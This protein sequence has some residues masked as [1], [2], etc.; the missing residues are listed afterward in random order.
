[1]GNRGTKGFRE[2][3]LPKFMNWFNC[4]RKRETPAFRPESN[5]DV[6][7]PEILGCLFIYP[8]IFYQFETDFSVA[9]TI[10]PIQVIS[11]ILLFNFHTLYEFRFSDWLICTT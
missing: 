11:N 1:M 3:K 9:E 6:L 8:R 2:E 4:F 7:C 5:R 10:V